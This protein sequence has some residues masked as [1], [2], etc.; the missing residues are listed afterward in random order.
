MIDGFPAGFS[1]HADGNGWIGLS[2][3]VVANIAIAALTLVMLKKG[4][5]IK[6]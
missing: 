5:K 2:V 4:Y 1:G 3:L 6:S